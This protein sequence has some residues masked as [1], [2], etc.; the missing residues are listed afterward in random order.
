M[1][2]TRFEKN[3][4]ESTWIELNWIEYLIYQDIGNPSKVIHTTPKSNPKSKI[5]VKSKTEGRVNNT[6]NTQGNSKI[7]NPYKIE[8]SKIKHK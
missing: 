2:R 4:M 1:S 8:T 3:S 6:S 5:Q 7:W